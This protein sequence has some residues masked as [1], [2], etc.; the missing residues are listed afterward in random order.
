MVAFISSLKEKIGAYCD[1]SDIVLLLSFIF[2]GGFNDFLACFISIALLVY[3]IFKI[4]KNGIL[5]IRLNFLTIACFCISLF[6][7]FTILWAIDSGMAFIGFLKY[8]PLA[9]YVIFLSQS[10]KEKR[11]LEILPLFIAV[12]VIVSSVCSLIPPIKDF[13]LVADRLAGFFQY[14]NTFA[15]LLLICELLVIGKNKFSIIDYI[16]LLVLI[17]GLLYTGSRTVF[18]LFLVSNFVM[19]LAKTSG[20]KRVVFFAIAIA[21]LVAILAVAFLGGEGN[22]LSRYL[23][24]GLTESTFVGRLLYIVDALPLLLKYPFGLGYYGYHFVQGSLQTGVY[25]VSFVHND[26]LQLAL[27]V[28]IIPALIFIITI[29]RYFFKK[30]IP[31]NKKIIVA[32]FVIH[33]MLDFNLQFVGMFML[34]LLLL[35]DNRGKI[36]SFKK[37]SW[38]K[39]LLPTLVL[40]NLYMGVALTLSQFTAY[41]AADALY[42]YNTRNKLLLLEQQEDVNEANI[43][44]DE[45]L[46]YNTS[47]YAPYSIK[48]KYYYSKGDFKGVIESKNAVFLRNRF[49]YTEFKEY[50]IMLVNGILAYEQMGDSASANVLKTEL[51]SLKAGMESNKEKISRLGSMINE[52]PITTLPNDILQYIDKITNE[53]GDLN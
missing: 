1:F 45:I 43:I 17:F 46:E 9:L 24:I 29:V 19:I 36:I 34:L 44:A 25:N 3:L 8:L 47:Y 39:I 31:F 15:L 50:G 12:L 40:L 11:V 20:R 5:E 37:L 7:G 14:P 4:C 26:F 32:V 22:V 10:G 38:A 28:G 2:I 48:A 35:D 6:Y 23:K 21:A 51:L 41:N 18:V 27:D 16:T 53:A 42:P 30:D 33:S 52:Q 13:F 49:R